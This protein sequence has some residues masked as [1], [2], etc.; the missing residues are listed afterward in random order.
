M[1]DL[2]FTWLRME[3]RL[4]RATAPCTWRVCL[5]WGMPHECVSYAMCCSRVFNGVPTADDVLYPKLSSWMSRGFRFN[6]KRFY[7]H[8]GTKNHNIIMIY[9]MNIYEGYDFVITLFCIQVYLP[10]CGMG[11]GRGRG[12]HGQISG[13]DVFQSVSKHYRFKVKVENISPN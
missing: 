3:L 9:I 13:R 8:P 1:T 7:L 10:R 6:F 12:G 5:L 2:I 4:P 11:R